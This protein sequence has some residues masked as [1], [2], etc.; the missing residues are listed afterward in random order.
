MK[1]KM[2]KIFTDTAITAYIITAA[3]NNHTTSYYLFHIA[4]NYCCCL[5]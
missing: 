1:Q 4:L 3:F 5:I 2:L